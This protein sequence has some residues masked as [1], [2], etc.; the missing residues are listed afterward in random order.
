MFTDDQCTINTWS[1]TRSAGESTSVNRTETSNWLQVESLW[2]HLV[3]WVEPLPPGPMRFH[4]NNN[5]SGQSSQLLSHCF[6][7]PVFINKFIVIWLTGISYLSVWG[8]TLSDHLSPENTHRY[9][10]TSHC[11]DTGELRCVRWLTVL[12]PLWQVWLVRQVWTGTTE[13]LM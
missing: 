4:W 8:F 2:C 9:S 11:V 7:S 3:W 6:C 1:I 10:I 5:S 12:L 13:T